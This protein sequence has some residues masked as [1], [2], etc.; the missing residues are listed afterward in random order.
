MKKVR[1]LV[2]ECNVGALQLLRRDCLFDRLCSSWLE[3]RRLR[4]RN[5]MLLI[6]LHG[7]ISVRNKVARV[8][9]TLPRVKWDFLSATESPAFTALSAC[10]AVYAMCVVDPEVP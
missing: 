3:I 9:Q 1:T 10:L 6:R 8:G 7:Y 2:T 5:E 4:S